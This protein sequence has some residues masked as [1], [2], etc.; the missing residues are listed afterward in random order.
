MTTRVHL[1]VIRGARRHLVIAGRIDDLPEDDVLAD[2]LI[3]RIEK[4]VAWYAAQLQ[5]KLQTAKTVEPQP[6]GPATQPCPPKAKPALPP[7]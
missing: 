5:A 2:E 7:R 3:A 4:S 1:Q 6:A